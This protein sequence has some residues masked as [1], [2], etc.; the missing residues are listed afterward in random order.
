MFCFLK[1]IS[2]QNGNSTKT[3]TSS[4]LVHN[5]I[6]NAQKFACRM[7]EWMNDWVIEWR[8]MNNLS[9]GLKE[10]GCHGRKQRSLASADKH[11]GL[12]VWEVCEWGHSKDFLSCDRIIILKRTA[13]AKVSC[14]SFSLLY[15]DC[16]KITNKK[17]SGSY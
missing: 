17:T 6:P 1:S 4:F 12:P 5:Y 8:L 2:H 7:N 15:W 3:E 13:L 14:D 9:R 16:L 11:L 10:R